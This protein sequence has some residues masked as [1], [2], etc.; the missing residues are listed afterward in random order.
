LTTHR[1]TRQDVRLVSV[2]GVDPSAGAGVLRDVLTA[3]DLGARAVVVGTA[4]TVQ[5]DRAPSVEPRDAEKVRL[6]LAAALSRDGTLPTAAKI[7]MVATSAI[8]RVVLAGLASFPGPIV[9]DPVLRA[10]SGLSLYAGDRESVLALARRATLLTPNLDEAGW[11][12]ERPVRTLVE[13]RSAARALRALGI[14]AVLVKGGH[15]ADEA[16]DVL[17]SSAGESIHAS[18]RH[19]GPSPRG[20]GCALGTAV[21]VE[22]AAG[23]PLEDAVA[24]AKTWLGE[25]I[26]SA[27]TVAGERHL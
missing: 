22:L 21:A 14:A 25:R 6:A 1:H 19:A 15:L 17:C 26:G 2:G 9:F 11:L 16:T 4:W 3:R 10:T 20:T 8:A 27:A 13:A 7:G 12:L 23:H 5:D 18:P 24:A